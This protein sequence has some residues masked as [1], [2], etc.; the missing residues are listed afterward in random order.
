MLWKI[1]LF[2]K[3]YFCINNECISMPMNYGK[4]LKI[5]SDFLRVSAFAKMDYMR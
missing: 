3:E 2:L 1:C 5:I 4:I